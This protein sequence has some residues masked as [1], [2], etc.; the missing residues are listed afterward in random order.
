MSQAIVIGGSIAG[1]LTARVLLDHYD[2]VILLERDQLPDGPEVRP[3]VPQ[4]QH[5]HALL[6]Q[7]YHLVESLFPN[8]TDDL[9]AQGAQ[10]LDWTNDW[11]FLTMW[12]WMP[13]H[14]SNLKGLICSRLLLEWYLRQQLLQ[15]SGF[16]LKAQTCAQSLI[17]DRDRI[18]GVVIDHKVNGPTTLQAD[19]VVDASGRRSQ[20]PEWLMELGY[21]PVETSAVNSFLGYASRW[22]E[23]APEDAIEG[24][25]IASKP[26]TTRRGGV[27]YPVEGN[28][29]VITLS[30]FEKDY[31]SNQE[32]EFLEFAKSLRDPSI[33]HAIQRA[34]PLSPIY[35]Y[36]NT[37][38]CL[39]HYEKLKTMPAGLVT[40][41]DAVCAFNPSYGQGMTVAS[42]G[43]I[44]LGDCLDDSS[45]KESLNSKF[46]LQ[47]QRKLA[48][49]IEMPWM[50]ATGED[51]RWKM[52]TGDR[53]DWLTRKTQG[54]FDRV[55]QAANADIKIYDDFLQVAHMAK[56]PSVLFHPRTL[57]KALAQSP[58]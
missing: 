52:T 55:V 35:C 27:V 54:Y 50:M 33:Y 41:G 58:G 6:L 40:L 47:F 42:L 46:S 8:L 20:L 48:K 32:D 30:G 7:G 44:L 4:A 25:I 38:N 53:P 24:V 3:G 10:L 57:W 23:Y 49:V 13:Q 45:T 14:K 5:V 16:S 15:R 22:Y 43:A 2:H 51:F 29:C 1:L 18:T 37:A 9:I 31:P 26:G 21:G 12:A 17:R 39:R 34:Q 19:L 11:K 28:R 56:S 36:R